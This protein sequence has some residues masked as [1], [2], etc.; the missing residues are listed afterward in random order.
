MAMECFV[1]QIHVSYESLSFDIPLAKTLH[2][3]HGLFNLLRT[4]LKYSRYFAYI[5]PESHTEVR[6][7]HRTLRDKN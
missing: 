7:T 6:Q 4:L 5:D 3:Q 1:S 2:Y